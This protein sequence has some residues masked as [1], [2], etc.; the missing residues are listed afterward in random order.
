MSEKT[1]A[2]N[3]E[4][5]KEITETL[6]TENGAKKERKKRNVVAVNDEGDGLDYELDENGE[7]RPRYY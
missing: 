1:P 2:T 6:V 7:W 4:E 5:M 3:S